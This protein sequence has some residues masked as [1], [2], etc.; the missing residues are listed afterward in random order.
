MHLVTKVPSKIDVKWKPNEENV[1]EF[2]SED[3]AQNVGHPHLLSN[4][5]TN[6]GIKMKAQ[7]KVQ[8]FSDHT[9]RVQMNHIR[10]YT[11]TGPTTFEAAH[12][13]L[14]SDEFSLFGASS[15]GLTEFKKYLEEPMM[16]SLKRGLMKNMIVS[17]DEPKCVIIVKKSLFA[18]LQNVDSTFGLKHLKKQPILAVLPVP[19]RPKKI[20]S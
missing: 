5:N 16:I 13:I 6:S 15:Q 17:K 10:F 1:F 4:P 7:V 18:E 20:D 2:R 14:G 12:E 3:L 19:S 9:L 11:S 8:S